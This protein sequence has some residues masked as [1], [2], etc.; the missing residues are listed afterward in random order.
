MSARSPVRA[1][2]LAVVAGHISKTKHKNSDTHLLR[3]SAVLNIVVSLILTVF[4]ILSICL[5][6]IP[7]KRP[8]KELDCNEVEIDGKIRTICILTEKSD[9][10]GNSHIVH[11]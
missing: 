10:N 6:F 7:L 3:V 8:R 1:P 2:L 4:L 11:S 5:I 9:I